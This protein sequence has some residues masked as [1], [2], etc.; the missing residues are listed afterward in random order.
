MTTGAGVPFE[1]LAEDQWW[2]Q[3]CLYKPDEVYREELM[4]Y[5]KNLCPADGRDGKVEFC[6][7]F[8]PA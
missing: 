2:S 4:R 7:P 1:D 5:R 3:S 6:W 8:V